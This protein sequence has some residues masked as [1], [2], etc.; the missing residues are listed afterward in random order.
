MTT[1]DKKRKALQKLRK[2]VLELEY[3][4]SVRA[5]YPRVAKLVG[6]HFKVR[7]SYS[8]PRGPEDYWFVYRTLVL[9]DKKEGHGTW[10]EFQV[11]KDG[12]LTVSQTTMPLEAIPGDAIPISEEEFVLARRKAFETF[13]RGVGL[14]S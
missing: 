12:Q 5:H 2:E 4:E 1:L 10:H 13:S 11:D 9:A 8:C 3:A 6:K 14:P 7:N